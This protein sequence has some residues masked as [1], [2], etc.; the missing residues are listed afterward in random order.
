MRA[1]G[2]RA[3]ALYSRLYAI[4]RIRGLRTRQNPGDNRSCRWRIT[5]YQRVKEASMYCPKCSHQTTSNSVRFC[6]GCGFR[7]DGVAELVANNGVF[8]ANEE[9]AP[10]PRR[11][12][13][14]RGALLGAALMFIGGLFITLPRTGLRGDKALFAFFF[15]GIAL[16]TLIGVSGFV[17]R[18]ITKIF[19]E[20]EPLPSK[21]TASPRGSALPAAYSEPVVN[22]RQ[23]F[24][25][26]A[27]MEQPSS[28]IEQT[29]SRLNNV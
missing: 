9:K 22:S 27:K 2:C 11:S 8:A 29:T 14:K 28:I 7:M 3:A 13:V 20:E 19:S 4:A 23:Q 24:V 17:K 6:P 15:Y 16:M 5:V 10:K 25:D 1:R 21:K 26:T 18:L 12:M